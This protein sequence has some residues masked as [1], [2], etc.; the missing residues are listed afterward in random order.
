MLAVYSRLGE[1]AHY[2]ESPVQNAQEPGKREARGGN[3]CQR[4]AGSCHRYY[5]ASAP[6]GMLL[7]ARF[8]K[9]KSVG[10]D[11]RSIIGGMKLLQYRR[12][13]RTIEKERVYQQKA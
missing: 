11:D 9:Q 1:L 12:L 3:V 4:L 8:M 2:G 13:Y 5:R 7:V 6:A 10:I